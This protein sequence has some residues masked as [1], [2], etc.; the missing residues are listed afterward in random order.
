MDLLNDESLQQKKRIRL[1]I[2]IENGK[3]FNALF[4]L[5][6]KHNVFQR[7]IQCYNLRK[8]IRVHIF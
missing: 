3:K 1:I 7:K 5:E 4:L 6:N 2:K 8:F